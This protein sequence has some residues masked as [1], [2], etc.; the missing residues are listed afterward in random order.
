METEWGVVFQNALT[1][2]PLSFMD[3]HLLKQFALYQRQRTLAKNE[4]QKQERTEL[5][6]ECSKMMYAQEGWIFD[7]K[8]LDSCKQRA[9]AN[10]SPA[11]NLELAN[12]LDSIIDDLDILVIN[13]NT[14]RKL[15]TSDVPVV[16]INPFHTPSIGYAC[17]GLILMFPISP[18]Q[19]V[20][21]Y[22]S[23][24]YP[25]FRNILYYE[26][27][28]EDEVLHLNTFQLISGEKILCSLTGKEFSELTLHGST[29]KP[30][31]IK[32]LYQHLVQMIT[33]FLFIIRE[34]LSIAVN[35]RS[36]KY[37]IVFVEFLLSAKKLHREN[38][39]KSGRKSLT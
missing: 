14:K 33:S 29:E 2:K 23:K 28:N 1:K 10:C 27:D 3:I 5:L 25:R 19:L 26:S 31:A 13:Y 39:I 22:D 8:A 35:Y 4:H 36:G 20:V 12:K 15:I 16:A 18:S 32:E 6:I 11:E 17:I 37:L 24:M 9:K 7:E 30:I 38:G 34:K 21:L